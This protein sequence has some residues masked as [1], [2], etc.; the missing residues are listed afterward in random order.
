MRLLEAPI[1]P[2]LR[3]KSDER[4]GV[5]RGVCDAEQQVDRSWPKGGETDAGLTGQPPVRLG[6]EGGP[7]FVTYEDE[8][9]R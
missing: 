2:D 9:D 5:G 7:L 6:H 4:G 8:S 1:H 3:G